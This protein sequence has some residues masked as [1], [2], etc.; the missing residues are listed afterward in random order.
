MR[1]ISDRGTL[2]LVLATLTFAANFSV[3][4]MYAAMT[5]PLT[6]S[7]HLSLTE[8]GLLLSTPMLTGAL[9]R[10]PAGLLADRFSVKG[11]W[12]GQMLLTL[13]PLW[14]LQ[15]ADSFQDYLLL[16]LWLGLS[17][18]SFTFGIRYVTT[19][20]SRQLQ[21]TS[22]GIFGAGNA[23]AAINLLLIPY[24]VDYGDWQHIGPLYCIGL[25]AVLVL[26]WF[27]A[28]ASRESGDRI[29]HQGC[30]T[31]L[32]QLLTRLHIWR[33]GLY[34][35]FVFGSFLALL[36]WLPHYYMNAY[37]LSTHQAMAFTLLFVASSSLVR[38]LGGWLADRFGGRRINWAVFWICLVC[39]FF[40]SY[41][42]TT[43]TIHGIDKDVHLRLGINLWVFTTLL[44]VIGIAQGL[45]RA[46]VYKLIQDHYPTQ[47]GSAG[48]LVAAMG[49]MGGCTLPLLF[50]WLVDWSGFYSI[51]FM[52]LYGVLA[53]CMV[54][55]YLAI[56]AE[57]FQKRLHHAM[58]D[59]F[60]ERD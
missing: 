43:M 31:Q 26:F 36:M 47:M 39:L 57:R 11:L 15:M 12:A 30:I 20:F 55:M 21:G 22:M 28:P 34:Y 51:C 5:R 6:E 54:A 25:A 52:L 7:L 3:W 13:P 42:P 23:G 40:L 49:A 48:G 35:Y 8:L 33:L 1:W 17:G 45:G 29:G 27:I 41:P 53:A 18:S 16:G 37:K 2:A 24:L 58:E 10:I 44:F 4:T 59:N 60:L 38:P 9:T 19:F 50:G 46:S 32:T 56:Q 14:L